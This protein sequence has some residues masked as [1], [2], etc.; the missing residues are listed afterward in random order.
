MQSKADLSTAKNK[1]ARSAPTPLLIVTTQLRGRMIP[2]EHPVGKLTIQPPPIPISYSSYFIPP[3]TAFLINGQIHPETLSFKVSFSRMI[4][5][6]CTC[7]YDHPR[8]KQE[9]EEGN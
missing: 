8:T 7:R 1:P 3:H 5:S 9:G 6:A 4:R 2:L